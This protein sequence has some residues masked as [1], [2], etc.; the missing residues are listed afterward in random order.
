M[1]DIGR[2]QSASAK[3]NATL[4][5][6]REAAFSIRSLF[7]RRMQLPVLDQGVFVFGA[8]PN[9]SL[10][11]DFMRT[12]IVVT[13]NGSQVTLERHGIA[14]PDITFMRTNLVRNWPT[15]VLKRDLL[16]DRQTGLLM[17]FGTKTDPDGE[18]HL[19]IL[20]EAN[21]KYDELIVVNRVDDVSMTNRLL[22]ER[23][24]WWLTRYNESMGLT[25]VLTCLS[26][27]AKIVVVSGIS[28][29]SDGFSFSD[30]ASERA[31]K[32]QDRIVLNKLVERELPVSTTD[33][34]LAVDTG[35]E[36]FHDSK[37]I[38]HSTSALDTSG[39]SSHSYLK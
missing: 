37:G 6:H 26:M 2:Q 21:Y 13:V 19:K 30:M 24:P 27:R 14:K 8:A 10:P 15:S 34:E 33:E 1:T 17:L 4:S 25:A 16:R 5:W 35:L 7:R 31:H 22:K 32:Q 3:G 9:Y 39:G 12:A 28:L 38:F 29:R 20:G 36:L 11:V 18:Q 23:F